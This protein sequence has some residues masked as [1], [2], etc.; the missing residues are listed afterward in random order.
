MVDGASIPVKFQFQGHYGEKDLT[1]AI[2]RDA[3]KASKS[4]MKIN[5]V[6]SPYTNEWETAMAYDAYNNQPLG[7]IDKKQAGDQVKM[8]DPKGKVEQIQ[9]GM[10]GLK[11]NN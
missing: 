10:T 5:I 6:W 9:K 2:P 3:L 11:L 7:P 8:V 4:F 1:L